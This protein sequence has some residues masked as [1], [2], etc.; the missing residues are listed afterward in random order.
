VPTPLP[1]FAD[2]HTARLV[3][4][5]VAES[6]LADLLEVNGDDEVTRYLPYATWRNHDDALAWLAR[7]QDRC[8]TGTARQYVI[9]RRPDR[10]VIGTVLVFQFDE[11]SARVEIGYVVGR[12]HWRQGYAT[13]ALRAVCRHAFEA[14]GIRRIE[15][16]ARP[17]NVASNE[18]LLSLGF[19]HEGRLRQRWVAKD[20]TYDTNIY[21][22]L[23]DDWLKRNTGG[24]PPGQ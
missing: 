1:L 14:A 24:P 8:A 23:L 11:P 10:K 19:T 16:E 20:E 5:A 13:E 18:L 3:I 2:I 17:D 21:G 4:R 12:A 6:D 22:L 15:A 9:E 7:M